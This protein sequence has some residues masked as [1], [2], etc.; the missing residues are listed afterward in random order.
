MIA[1][2]TQVSLGTPQVK[3]NGNGTNDVLVDVT[4]QLDPK[5]VLAVPN[6]YFWDY[7]H[8]PLKAGDVDFT[9][10]M[11]DKTRGIVVKAAS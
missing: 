9:S 10:H 1:T 5:P 3:D 4:W 11:G 8:E 7:R 2:G 6:K